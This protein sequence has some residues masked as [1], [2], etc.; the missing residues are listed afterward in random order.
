MSICGFLVVKLIAFKNLICAATLDIAFLSFQQ[1]Y[2]VL[3]IVLYKLVTVSYTHLDVYKR[4]VEGCLIAD[5]DK[6]W[7]LDQV[8]FALGKE[9]EQIAEKSL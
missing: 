6:R 3:V 9:F 4:Q 1:G 5:L 8:K 7:T 2:K